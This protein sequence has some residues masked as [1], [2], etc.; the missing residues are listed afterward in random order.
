MEWHYPF[1]KRDSTFRDKLITGSPTFST[2][3][4]ALIRPSMLTEYHFL[5]GVGFVASSTSLDKSS[6]AS[7]ACGAVKD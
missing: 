1:V 4:A 6:V 3:S 2:F 5:L 7:A